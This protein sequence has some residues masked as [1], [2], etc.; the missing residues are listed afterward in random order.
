[1]SIV[2]GFLFGVGNGI[3][4]INISATLGAT[5]FFLLVRYFI[6]SYV[7]V[8]YA[9]KLLSFNQMM[10]KKGWLFILTIRCIPLIPFFMVNMLAGLTALPI[11]TF[12]WTTSLG[13][14]PTSVIFAYAGKEFTKLTSMRDIFS[15]PILVA[16]ILLLML[17]LI[18]VIVHRYRKIF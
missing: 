6:G 17:V 1:M 5:L 8:R 10:R 14:V 15:F 4:Y 3:F 12:M 16:V 9:A 18:P 11:R 13:I 2:G 7:Q